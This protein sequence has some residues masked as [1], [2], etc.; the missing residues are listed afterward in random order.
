MSEQ[1]DEVEQCWREFWLP[2]V[3]KDGAVDIEQVKKEL[4]DFKQ[5]MRNASIVYDHVTRS[6][7]TNVLTLP[8][9]VIGEADECQENAIRYAIEDFFLEGEFDGMDAD[10]VV[11]IGGY[12]ARWFGDALPIP[13][14]EAQPAVVIGDDEDGQID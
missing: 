10:T 8:D 2:I 3:A 1:M 13:V 4:F 9:A 5:L 7:I 6:R 12:M 14:Y 11:A